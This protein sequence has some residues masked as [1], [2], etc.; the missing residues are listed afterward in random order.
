ML[1]LSHVQRIFLARAPADMRKQATGL[2]NLVYDSLDQDPLSGDAFVFLNRHRTIVKILAWDVS[3]YWVASKRLESGRFAGRKWLAHSDAGGSVGL[4]VSELMNI[5]EGV[6]V[7]RA[8]YHQHY[9][10][11]PTRL[12]E[13]AT[14]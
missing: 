4:S 6:D 7:E 3:G 14:T 12:N 1:S 2:S 8:A 13:V 11:T 10:A 9:S 5:L